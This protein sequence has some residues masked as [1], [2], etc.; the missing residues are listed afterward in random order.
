[1]VPFELRASELVCQ[2]FGATSRYLNA[3]IEPCRNMPIVA[4]RCSDHVLS[5]KVNYRVI[6]MFGYVIAAMN[7][8]RKR[9]SVSSADTPVSSSRNTKKRAICKCHRIQPSSSKHGLRSEFFPRPATKK[10]RYKILMVT[11]QSIV[12]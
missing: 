9:S 4:F 1:M 8:K 6:G 3:F 10:V 5:F 2:F 12:K 7:K 11:K